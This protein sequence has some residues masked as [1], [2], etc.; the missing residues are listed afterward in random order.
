M[1]EERGPAETARNTEAGSKKTRGLGKWDGLGRGAKL[2]GDFASYL[3]SPEILPYTRP[4]SRI[5]LPLPPPPF[6]VS[7]LPAPFLL[8]R[9]LRTLSPGDAPLTFISGDEFSFNQRP[10]SAKGFRVLHVQLLSRRVN[11][12]IVI[13]YTQLGNTS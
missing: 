10:T 1:E 2:L 7:S 13:V 4:L 9:F 6:S 8:S 3:I 5:P 11:L 12:V